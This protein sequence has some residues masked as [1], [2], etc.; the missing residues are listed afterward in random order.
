MPVGTFDPAT[1]RG[2]VR[3]LLGDWQDITSLT[4]ADASID[5]FLTMNGDDI[6][7]AGADGCRALAS[8]NIP[9]A[10]VLGIAG[11]INIDQRDIS[12]VW[13]ALASKY[14]SRAMGGTQGVVEYIDSV[15][16]EINQFG[17]DQSE[18]VGDV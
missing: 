5:A 11:A 16:S 9:N 8:L 10:F 1:D 2:Q 7:M 4:F 12:K 3:L 18:Y 15:A 6:W 17:I 14:E 13:L